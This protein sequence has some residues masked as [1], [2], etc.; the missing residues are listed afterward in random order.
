VPGAF[1]GFELAVR[2]ILG[3]RVSVRAA[4]TLA[5]RL[6]DR[7]GEPIDTPVPE[8]FRLSP[9]PAQ[10]MA[11][12]ESELTKLGISAPRAK[13]IRAVARA[14]NERTLDLEPGPDP[15]AVTGT[16]KQLPGIGE[17]T[18]QYIAMRALR[19]PD[20][21]PA[22]DLGLLKAWGETSPR[23]LRDASEA[24]RPWRSYAAMYL[25]ENPHLVESETSSE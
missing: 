19:W 14:V 22:G 24:W 25:W 1:D 16:L 21:F 9:S 17:W 2:A 8:L 18:A 3:Q 11:A 20:A 6:A 4:T 23:R 7:M 12:Q 5:S 15:E 13:C 10:L